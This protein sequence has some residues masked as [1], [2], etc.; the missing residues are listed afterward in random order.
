MLL[1]R[2]NKHEQ[3]HIEGEDEH[4]PTQQDDLLHHSKCSDDPSREA[5]NRPDRLENISSELSNP[6]SSLSVTNDVS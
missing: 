2:K 6:W 1:T 5:Q 4:A 3:D